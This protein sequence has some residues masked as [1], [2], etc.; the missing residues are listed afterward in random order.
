MLRPIYDVIVFG[1]GTAG[2]TAA[3]QA[4]GAAAALCAR[5]DIDP[6]DLSMDALREEL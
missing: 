3:V 2:V 4:A 5:S 1:G 6:E